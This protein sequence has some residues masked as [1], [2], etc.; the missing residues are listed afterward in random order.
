MIIDSRL[1]RAAEPFIY[2]VVRALR[3]ADACQ[4]QEITT[5]FRHSYLST[6]RRDVTQQSNNSGGQ[7]EL[8]STLAHL[9]VLHFILLL[10]LLS[11][12]WTV[13]TYAID[14]RAGPPIPVAPTVL[15]S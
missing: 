7:A 5:T 11:T 14:C 9:A 8:V 4:Q 12:A 3:T 2:T 10:S 6:L 1:R 15:A 13:V